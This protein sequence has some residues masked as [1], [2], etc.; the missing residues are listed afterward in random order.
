MISPKLSPPS[1][2]RSSRGSVPSSQRTDRLQV[3]LTA[4]R[5]WAFECVCFSA[6]A[7]SGVGFP[8]SLCAIPRTPSLQ[9]QGCALGL[10]AG[11]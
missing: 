1:G 5:L 2:L 8:L 11:A 4:R 6:I 3:S 10:E 7:L 9:M